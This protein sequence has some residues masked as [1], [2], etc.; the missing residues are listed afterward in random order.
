M[1]ALAQ[2][3]NFRYRADGGINIA[4]DETTEV[5]DIHAIVR[6]VGNRSGRKSALSIRHCRKLESE[7][8]SGPRPHIGVPDTS[9]VQHAPL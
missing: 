2:H 6:A 9:S 8:S 1:S 5:Q 7:I 3:L 4:L